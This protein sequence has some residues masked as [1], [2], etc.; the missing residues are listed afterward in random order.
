LFQLEKLADEID[1]KNHDQQALIAIQARKRDRTKVNLAR[2]EKDIYDIEIQTNGYQREMPR[3]GLQ[4]SQSVENGQGLIETN[5]HFEAEILENLGEKELEAANLETQIESI[6]GKREELAE[7][8]METEKS[9]MLM[10][11]K[12]QLTKEMKDALDPNLRG[13]EIEG[14]LK[15][16]SSMELYLKQLKKQ[17]SRILQEMSFALQMR[18]TIANRRAVQL[19]L[20]KDKT[21]VMS[22][23]VFYLFKRKIPKLNEETNNYSLQMQKEFE[24]QKD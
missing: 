9:I 8:L 23:K 16:I 20:N 24:E 11:K 5:I 17:Q 22:V 18:E 2:T 12:I 4:L 1:H 21:R 7:D 19:R 3:L 14:I 13:A 10:E 6:A 15:E